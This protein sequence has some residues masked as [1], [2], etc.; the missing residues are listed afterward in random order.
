MYFYYFTFDVIDYIISGFD[1]NRD[2]LQ[3]FPSVRM[4][5]SCHAA[6]WERT[7]FK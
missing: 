4:L 5:C 1:V 3:S 7:G 2:E 6:P